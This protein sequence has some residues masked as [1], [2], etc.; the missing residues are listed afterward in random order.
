MNKSLGSI[1]LGHWSVI[2][3]PD[4]SSQ[5]RGRIV[6]EK[7]LIEIFDPDEDG[8]WATFT[9]EVVEIKLRSVLRPYRLLVNSLIGVIQELSDSEK[10]KFIESLPQVFSQINRKVT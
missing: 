2:W 7:S 4:G 6:S 5:L 3:L 10:D 1:G 8:A 9:H